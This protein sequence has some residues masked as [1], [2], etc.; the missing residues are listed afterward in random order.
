MRFGVTSDSPG[1][2]LAMNLVN[3]S[4]TPYKYPM[5]TGDMLFRLWRAAVKDDDTLVEETIHGM[6]EA[7]MAFDRER[8]EGAM[9]LTVRRSPIAGDAFRSLLK[10]MQTFRS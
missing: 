2:E 10:D 7:M 6:Y 3:L 4:D 5:L 1:M 8:A 9:D